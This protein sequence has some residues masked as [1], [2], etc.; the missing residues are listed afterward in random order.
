MILRLHG[1]GLTPLAIYFSIWL[2]SI[3]KWFDFQRRRGVCFFREILNFSKK[4]LIAS[5]K[6]TMKSMFFIVL[7]TKFRKRNLSIFSEIFDSEKKTYYIDKRLSGNESTCKQIFVAS[8]D[9]FSIFIEKSKLAIY[10]I[11]RV[12]PLNS[13][14]GHLFKFCYIINN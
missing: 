14:I 9:D 5:E 11:N 12:K 13:K 8:F 2:T 10:E 7:S 4:V 6:S 3:V 1:F